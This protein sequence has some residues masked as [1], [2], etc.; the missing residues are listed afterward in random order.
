MSGKPKGRI[1][2]VIAVVLILGGFGYLLYGNI[3]K[4]LVWNVTPAE[5]LAKGDDAYDRAVRLGGQVAPGSIVWDEGRMGVNFQMQDTDGKQ[6]HVRSKGIP[7]AMFRDGIGVVVEGK[8]MKDSPTPVFHATNL[9]VKHSNEYQPP[10]EGHPARDMSKT[11]I[12]E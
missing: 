10:A 4:N 3:G 5:L 12:S 1:A 9:M 11:L 6:I 7:T 8:L 2:L